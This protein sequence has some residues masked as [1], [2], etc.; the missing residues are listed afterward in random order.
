MIQHNNWL[1]GRR[2]NALGCSI[3]IHFSCL[4]VPV[5]QSLVSELCFVNNCSSF[6]P[7][8]IAIVLS[9]LIR[10]KTSGCLFGIFTLFF[11]FLGFFRMY[12]ATD[13][14]VH[15]VFVPFLNWVHFFLLTSCWYV[16]I[17]TSCRRTKYYNSINGCSNN[18]CGATTQAKISMKKNNNKNEQTNKAK[19][20][21]NIRLFLV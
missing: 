15:F 4:C 5:A 13:G 21:A 20:N 1:T 6:V 9:V 8:R 12:F 17:I 11:I 2:W 16:K 19:L 7:F 3:C 18:I 14:V 10:F